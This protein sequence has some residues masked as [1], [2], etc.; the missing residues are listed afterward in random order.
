MNQL[1]EK[2]YSMRKGL[3]SKGIDKIIAFSGSSE[4]G[5]SAHELARESIDVFK[6]HNAAI[7]TGGTTWGLPNAV[8]EYA[9]SHNIPV[10]GV[11][12]E[13]G[14]KYVSKHLDFAIEVAAKYGDSEWGDDSEVFAKL[15]NGVEIIGGGMGTMIEFSHIMKI[16][17]SRIK[18]HLPVIYV[19][20]V[21]TGEEDF[22]SVIYRLPLKAEVRDTCMPEKLFINGKSA[23]KFLVER[24]KLVYGDNEFLTEVKI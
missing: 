20:P 7:L 3:M 17:E 5:D 19:A 15:V 6:N 9:K 24:L 8:A 22:S 1:E 13:R 11:L 14:R 2:I 23:A 21:K 12:P 18:Y 4:S 16:N 10:I